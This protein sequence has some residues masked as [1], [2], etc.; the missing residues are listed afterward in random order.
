[1]TDARNGIVKPRLDLYAAS[2]AGA[3]QPDLDVPT[4]PEWATMCLLGM[5]LLAAM[6]R[7][8]ARS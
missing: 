5:L 4:L 7:H 2:A 8:E 6:R 3:A 1:V